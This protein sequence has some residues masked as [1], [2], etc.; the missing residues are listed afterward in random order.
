MAPAVRSRVLQNTYSD[1]VELMRVAAEVER[2]P[3]IVRGR[4]LGVGGTA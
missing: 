2:L 4:R 3:G 1:S